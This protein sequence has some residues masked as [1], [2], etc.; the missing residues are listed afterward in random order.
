MGKLFNF[1]KMITPIMIKLFFWIGV[2]VAIVSGFFM[3]GYGI[4]AQNGSFMQVVIGI[5]SLFIGP[6]IIRIYCE[7]L[8]V[9]FKMQESLVQIRDYFLFEQKNI[10]QNS[11]ESNE[12]VN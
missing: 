10:K 2:L 1:D 4:I 5:I 3:I 12:G 8:I 6:L 11:Y 7:M 9:L